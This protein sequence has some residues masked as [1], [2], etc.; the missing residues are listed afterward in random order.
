M[1]GIFPLFAL[2]CILELHLI[3]GYDKSCNTDLVRDSC[4]ED[5]LRTTIIYIAPEFF[6]G[7]IPSPRNE[8]CV[9][10]DFN[11]RGWRCPGDTLLAA[12]FPGPNGGT[13]LR[14]CTK[15]G[16]K[17]KSCI[18]DS[19]IFTFKNNFA[20]R[21]PKGFHLKGRSSVGDPTNPMA[22]RYEFCSL[23]PRSHQYG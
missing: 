3:Q 10:I 22:S 9:L 16:L 20:T 23:Q 4:L 5:E 1:K 12:D 2:C 21:P 11:V 6:V 18:L 13:I 15:K 8:K 7:C 14:C 17:I 19:T